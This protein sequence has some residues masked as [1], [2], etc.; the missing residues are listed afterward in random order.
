MS[1]GQTLVVESGRTADNIVLSDLGA[2]DVLLG[3][4]ASATTVSNGAAELV[5]AGGFDGGAFIDG[6]EQDVS[7]FA[8]GAAVYAGSQVVESGGIASGSTVFSGGTIELLSGASASA[9]TISSGGTL[10]TAPGATGII[11]GT[12]SGFVVSSG[13]TLEVSGGIVSNTTV[14]RG[15]TLELVAGARLSGTTKVSSGGI[16]EIGS[17][18]TLSGYAPSTGVSLDVAFDGSV[19][20]TTVTGGR[21]LVEIRGRRNE[22][23]CQG[24]RSR[25]RIL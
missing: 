9:V 16:L 23:D 12:L 2:L 18:A 11:G 19:S 7:G 1:A 10:E 8:G 13:V 15:G 3:G 14:L 6:G 17:G 5:D 22:H 4:T 20:N 25:N 24:R 21:L